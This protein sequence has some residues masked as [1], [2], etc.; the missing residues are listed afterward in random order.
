[1]WNHLR[2]RY[3]QEFQSSDIS[4]PSIAS[5]V[6]EA[7]ISILK[8]NR[9]GD[10]GSVDRL[11]SSPSFR[12]SF[13]KLL[14]HYTQTVLIAGAVCALWN[15]SFSFCSI[16]DVTCHRLCLSDSGF[17]ACYQKAFI[18]AIPKTNGKQIKKHIACN[19]YPWLLQLLAQ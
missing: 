4:C 19:T 1:M 12:V 14:S 8:A 15:G 10:S 7:G 11:L 18:F 5:K 17:H 3:A 13:M 2:L 6:F 9:R 16:C